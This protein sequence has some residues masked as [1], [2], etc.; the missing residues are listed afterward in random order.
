MQ[1]LRGLADPVQSIAVVGN[2]PITAYQRRQIDATDVVIRFNKLDNW[3][4]A[5]Q[6][7]QQKRAFVPSTYAGRVREGKS[8]CTQARRPAWL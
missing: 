4:A 5:R 3:C 8:A 6:P 7:V 2:G 1:A